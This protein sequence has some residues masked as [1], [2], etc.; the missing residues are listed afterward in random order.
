MRIQFEEVKSFIP[1]VK[2][3]LDD[4]P[5]VKEDQEVEMATPVKKRAR[6]E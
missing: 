5:R 4:N 6:K 2:I 3:E 1:K